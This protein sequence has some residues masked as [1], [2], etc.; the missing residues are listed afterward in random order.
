MNTIRTDASSTEE[1]SRLKH[2]PNHYIY[3]QLNANIKSNNASLTHSLS[4]TQC[5]MSWR[6]NHW[7]RSMI[8]TGNNHALSITQVATNSTNPVL[9][10]LHPFVSSTHISKQNHDQHLSCSTLRLDREW[11]QPGM[12]H[13][14][15]L[16][17]SWNHNRNSHSHC[18]WKFEC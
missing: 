9:A 6:G 15:K 16:Q 8:S 4:N 5:R 13:Q 2:T 11:Q 7:C 12:L 10:W 18:S 3:C 17:A 1:L 14:V